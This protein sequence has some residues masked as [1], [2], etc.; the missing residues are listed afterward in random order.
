MVDC[1]NDGGVSN[2][3]KTQHVQLKKTTI[4]IQGIPTPRKR[5]NFRIGLF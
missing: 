5:G 3:E 4:R 2:D 1:Q